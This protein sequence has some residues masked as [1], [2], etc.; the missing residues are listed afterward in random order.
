MLAMSRM[1]E[2]IFAEALE[3]PSPAARAAFLESTCGN[4]AEMRGRIENL[5]KSHTGA[6]SFL[7]KPF[8]AT[9]DATLPEKP[10]AIIGPYKLL[11][12]I[13]EGGMGVVY[14][15]DQEEPVRRHVALKIIKPGMDSRQVIARFE[16]ER[17]ALAMMDHQNIAKVLDA[18]TTDAG[19]PYF[20]MELVH[21][22][23][24]TKF[25]DEN[26]LT[27]QQRLELFVPI[28]HAIQHAHQKGVIHRDIKPS[29]ILVTMYDD[30]PVPKV[31][32]F[33]VAKAMEQRL[34][35]KTLFTQYG[36]LV[37]TFEYMS[38]EQ[39]QMN[40]FGVDTRSDVYSLGVL[41]YEL[42][43]GT[44]PLERKRL[45]ETALQEMLRIIKEEE[46]PC[47]SAR[48][49]SS[50]TLPKVA[51]ACRTE[52]A[53]LPG[54]VR[55]ELDWIVMK[56]LEKD[57][58]RRYETA[59]GLAR[60]IQRYLSDEPVEACPPSMTYRFRKLASRHRGLLTTAAS[61][62]ALLVAGI[63]VSVWLAAWAMREQQVALVAQSQAEHALAG[64]REAHKEALDA[65]EKA[66]QISKQLSTATELANE[67]IEFYYA[68]NRA[69][70]LEKFAQAADV[71]PD[72]SSI[73]VYRRM[74]YTNLGLWDLAAADYAES[75]RISK[76][77][78][79]QAC[80]EHALLRYYVGDDPGYR[81]AC[82]ELLRQYGDSG[83]NDVQMRVLHAVCLATKPAEEPAALVRRAERLALAGTK[84]WHQ[85][86]VAL[87][88]LR[89]GKPERSIPI[90]QTVAAPNA[91]SPAGIHRAIFATLAMALHSER[92]TDEAKEA[93][94]K[95]DVAIDEWT[96]E[97]V[98]GT[99]GTLPVS[100]FDWLECL[101]LQRE[102]KFLLTG[103]SPAED[104]RLLTIRER[105]LEITQ[106]DVFTFMEAGRSA[107]Q[108]QDWDEA[109]AR[110]TTAMKKLSLAT[111]R[112]WQM[113]FYAEMVEQP[114]VFRRLIDSQPNQWMLW[115][116]RGHVFASRREW[117]PA[118]ADFAKALE[119]MPAEDHPHPEAWIKQSLAAL[120]LLAG[121][122]VAYRELCESMVD[123]SESLN[124]PIVAN[125]F[126]RSCSL[127]L[128]SIADRSVPLR[129]AEHALASSPKTSWYL[130]GV[131]AAHYRAGQH[132]EAIA[133]LEESLREQPTWSGRG[134]NYVVLALACHQL[135]RHD[136]ARDWLTKSKASLDELE[137]TIGRG[138]YSLVT[139]N[140]F[141]DW[142]TIL[143]LLPEAE[144]LLR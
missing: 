90:C 105:A 38:P 114:E 61:F 17:Q 97:M 54:I 79:Q 125:V 135:G 128:D 11:Q 143:V 81:A 37:G 95:F 5:L 62:A 142:L 12:Q 72:L 141:T 115:R 16:A 53:R 116:A 112:F 10:G 29:N 48:L 129:L 126:S 51:A 96:K 44:T 69:A 77:A 55:G 132:A 91:Q 63:I 6:G 118:A 1:E 41:L 123:S 134:Q 110:F 7:Q 33:G 67:G 121:D 94:A 133:R 36:T 64:A 99:V 106:G 109:A 2:S 9:V 52:P 98:E 89:A 76:R 130:F 18:G 50:G 8:A 136:E 102:A 88:F 21:G 75:F 138:R 58:S 124:I 87:G 42:L 31:I 4:D 86:A 30:K 139:S 100:W 103:T 144:K 3:L 24:V 26:R 49:S 35:E 84:P 32:D 107:I 43:T 120:Y 127:R 82:G 137:Q 78:H 113:P 15:A 68:N 92:R 19:Q 85:S 14:M 119:L 93:L 56:C 34:T 27:P 13:G 39:A 45:R 122:E 25:C 83:D 140:Y 66:E 46:P 111:H 59:N 40:A 57:R 74:I 104:P 70:A 108:R 60:D 131:G 101:L 20:V 65:K 47:P 73:Y 23:S 71:E 117:A 28:C 80:F 22:I